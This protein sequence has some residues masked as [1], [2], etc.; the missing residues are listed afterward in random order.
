MPDETEIII[1]ELSSIDSLEELTD[2]L[3]RAYRTLAEMKLKYTAT[4][5]DVAITKKRIANGV[6][7]VAL[8]DERLVGTIT[9]NPVGSS[10]G[11]AW[12]ESDGVAHVQQ[13]GV[14]PEYRG[15]GIGGRLM[16]T[17]EERAAND[18]ALELALD[19]AVPARQLIDWYERRG[20][21][22]IEKV[23]W[24]MT[25]YESVVMSKRLR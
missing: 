25:N 6:C 12:L 16:Q 5:Q 13:L 14:D 17:I 21:R 18:G 19:T 24:T 11:S 22:Y 15:R 2:L 8:H 3:N 9:Y 4:Y 7:F 23:N 20:Y 1:R 10:R